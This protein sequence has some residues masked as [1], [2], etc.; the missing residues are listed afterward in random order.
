MEGVKAGI[1]MKPLTLTDLVVP[2]SQMVEQK[3]PQVD[4]LVGVVGKNETKKVFEIIVT[5]A[6]KL[7]QNLK[8]ICC[9]FAYQ[10]GSD[11]WKV[12]TTHGNAQI[13]AAGKDFEVNVCHNHQTP[14]ETPILR[15]LI[16]LRNG[17]MSQSIGLFK[18]IDVP[19]SKIR[20]N[21][22]LCGDF[23]IWNPVSLLALR[24]IFIANGASNV[25]FCYTSY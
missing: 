14:Q 10:S 24:E 3:C 19:Y 2:L 9:L 6:A 25:V 7:G 22:L 21:V 8:D 20:G 13:L 23:S 11:K 4:L 12:L 17:L 1:V 15:Q 16:V 18:T 5:L